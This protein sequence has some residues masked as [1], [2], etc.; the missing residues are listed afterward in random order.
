MTEGGC[1]D[2]LTIQSIVDNEE[3]DQAAVE[4]LAKCSACKEQENEIRSIVIY[5]N[6]LAC[7]EKLPAEFFKRLSDDLTYKPFPAL[8]FALLMFATAITSAYIIEPGYFYW[9][10][11]VGITSTIGLFMDAFFELLY[12]GFNTE[13]VWIILLLAALVLVE[14]IALSGIKR[15][16]GVV[17]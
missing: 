12:F 11:T 13:P 5:A 15:L 17:K 3:V 6:Q 7:E 2:Y 10:L 9:W 16:E 8:L 4:H 1:L 14:V